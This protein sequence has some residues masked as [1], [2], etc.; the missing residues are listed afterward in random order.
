M[1]IIF[2]D[3]ISIGSNIINI[4]FDD[5]IHGLSVLKFNIYYNV[6]HIYF[7]IYL[8]QYCRMFNIFYYQYVN[9]FSNYYLFS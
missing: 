2:V 4:S 3:Y 9:I 1:S 7:K 8:V 5:N 6:F